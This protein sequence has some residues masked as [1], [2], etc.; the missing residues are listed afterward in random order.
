MEDPFESVE[1][2]SNFQRPIRLSFEIVLSDDV[3]SVSFADL[4]K[5]NEPWY[6]YYDSSKYGTGMVPIL[7]V[8]GGSKG[9]PEAI[10]KNLCHI[11]YAEE[12][13]E[14]RN[15]QRN[16][17]ELD[18]PKFIELGPVAPNYPERSTI[19]E[20]I[21]GYV[22]FA[23]LRGFSSWSLTATYDQI[24]EIYEVLADRI[25]QMLLDYPFSYWKLL[26]DGIMLVWEVAEQ[27]DISA[28]CAIGAAYELHKKYWYYR[29]QSSYKLPNGFGIA[30]AAGDIIKFSSTTFFESCVVND[31][32]GPT[33]NLAARLQT[34]AH[35][36]QV[37]VNDRVAKTSNSD[38]YKFEDVTSPLMQQFSKLKGIS[39]HEKNIYRVKHKYFKEDWDRF[40]S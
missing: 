2:K 4:P 18:I 37:L 6:G 34:L 31:Y 5:N 14:I 32:L 9:S 40:C 19:I 20:R 38:W 39:A 24:S 22:M 29:K 23:D 25:A 16:Y 15:I 10:A 30:I 8:W 7:N 11:I 28:N 3:I 33:V 1:F 13:K 26:G 21:I 12:P 17:V 36:G 35:P 27:E